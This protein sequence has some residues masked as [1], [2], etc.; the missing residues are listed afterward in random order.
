MAAVAQRRSARVRL[1]DAERRRLVERHIRLAEKIALQRCHWGHEDPD[2]TRSD[3][4]WGL[5][6]A[7][8]AF[9]PDRGS[10]TAYAALR[11]DY[12]IRR[13]RQVRSGLPRSAWEQ[14]DLTAP[15]SL[16][17][18][19]RNGSAELIDLLPDRSETEEDWL[20][21]AIRRLPTRQCLVLRLRY[22]SGL[23]QSEIASIIG[24]SQMQ[25]SRIERAALAALRD[26]AGD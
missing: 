7:G 12:A 15:I 21:D 22:Y 18:P 5:T 26:S 13:G 11:I 23:T 20:R 1:L 24:R 3:A 19:V 16:N 25:V 17:A 14:G 9:R 8:A 2:D 6:L 10:F 4:F